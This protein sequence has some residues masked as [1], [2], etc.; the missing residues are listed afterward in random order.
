MPPLDL[1]FKRWTRVLFILFFVAL[2]YVVIA[3]RFVPMTTESRVQGQVVQIATEVSGNVSEIMVTNNQEVEAGQLL[4]TLDD[5][6]FQLAVAQAELSL[7]QAREQFQ[8]LLAQIEAAQAQL[9]RAQASF[10]LARKELSR[11][12]KIA[13][14]QLISESILDQNHTRFLAAEADRNAA[15]Q[16]LNRLKAQL[17]NDSTSAVELAEVALE[18]AKLNLSYT[19]VHAPES[20]V[21][22]NLQ[23]AVGTYANAR[24]PLLS[25]VPTGSL[26]IAADY[27]EKALSLVDGQSRALVT[28]DALPGEVFEL[29]L[30]S[31]DM[32]VAQAQ[33]T[34]NGT[35]ASIQINNR[36]VR[37]AQRVRVN[38]EHRGALPPQLFI[39]SRASVVLYPGEGAI[40]QALARLQ[41]KLISCLHY[42]Y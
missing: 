15:R 7:Q 18:T 27:R 16:Q 28:Y 4:F 26:W 42:I 9:A 38:L 30:T 6:R 24:Q 39:G 37:D 2:G 23:L 1:V 3:D 13:R 41:V 31:R 5:R 36:W 20:G 11:A 35:L 34:A 40:W 14:E 21:V 25:F 8:A 22:S 12:Q 29:T 19:R 10:E 17:S 33:Q 32:G